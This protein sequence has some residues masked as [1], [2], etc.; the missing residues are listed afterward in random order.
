ME[1]YRFARLSL[2]RVAVLGLGVSGSAVVAYLLET[3]ERCLGLTVF[4]GQADPASDAVQALCARG[5]DVR[6]GEQVEGEFDLCIASP[7]IPET[8]A[9]YQSACGACGQVISE[10]E[11]AWRESRADSLWI[12]VTGTNGKTTTTALIAHLIDAAYQAGAQRPHHG[13]RVE[14]CGNIGTPCIDAVAA[15]NASG[16]ASVFVAEVSSYQLASTKRFAPNIGV[17]LGISPDHLTW[18]GSF[19]AYA[20]AK[21]RMLEHMERNGGVA[22]IDATNDCAREQ[23]KRLRTAQSIPEFS[24]VPLGTKAGITGDMRKACGAQNA[25]FKALDGTLTLASGNQ[26]VQLCNADD[27]A[28]KGTHNVVNALAAAAAAYAAGVDPFIIAQALP[29]FS[30]LEHRIE[31][32]GQVNSV[33]F[34]NDSK[35]TNV[36]ATLVAVAS[37]EPGSVVVMLG[38]RDK[39]GPLDELVAACNQYAKAVVLFGEARERF[40]EAFQTACPHVATVSSFDEAFRTACTLAKAGDSVLLSPACASFDEFSCFEER[41][42][43]FKELVRNLTADEPDGVNG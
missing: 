22:I 39:L 5:V 18:H 42:E 29:T 38:G 15:A 36:D 7:G 1:G 13:F 33:Q 31:P 30:A 34:F 24:Y 41:G 43:H 4:V 14:T 16:E 17:F 20:T 11:F 2:G 3:P 25:A 8:G 6:F 28:I 32:A 12:A 19:D 21:W 23:C 27:L 40:A 26:E 9:F 10:V 35:A 37:F